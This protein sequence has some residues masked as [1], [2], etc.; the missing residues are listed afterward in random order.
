MNKFAMAAQVTIRPALSNSQAANAVNAVFDSITD[1]L[2][3]G[4]AVTLT[5]YGTFSI[6]S[7][8]A[9]RGGNPRTG[10]PI[11]AAASTAPSFKP[12]KTLRDAVN[13]A[14]E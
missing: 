12:G 1:A 8:P 3:G 10:E 5:G 2:A 9:R 13:R 7:R 6:R 14:R 11:A 4:E